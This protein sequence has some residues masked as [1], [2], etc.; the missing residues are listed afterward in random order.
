MS[1]QVWGGSLTLAVA[2]AAGAAVPVWAHGV[3][4]LVSV[5][6][7]GAAAGGESTFPTISGRG[8]S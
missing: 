1:A 5:G 3:T 4:E 7:D 8:A 6:L 2:I